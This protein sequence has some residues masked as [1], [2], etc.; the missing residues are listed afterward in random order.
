MSEVSH[1]WVSTWSTTC[2][3]PRWSQSG[4]LAST[5]AEAPELNT[6]PFC[7]STLLQELSACCGSAYVS[8]DGE[9]KLVW[10]VVV[11]D[12]FWSVLLLVNT[13]FR[14]MCWAWGPYGIPWGVFF[15]AWSA[16][17]TGAKKVSSHELEARDPNSVGKECAFV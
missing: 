2:T 17:L 15:M 4:R 1:V 11:S 16:E 6:S 13:W 14:S 12:A 3:Q 8:S 5:R 9:E 7:I 10:W